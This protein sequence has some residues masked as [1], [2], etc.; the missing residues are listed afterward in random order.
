MC[1]F[2][3]DKENCRCEGVSDV[4]SPGPTQVVWL[5]RPASQLI[6]TI[7]FPFQNLCPSQSFKVGQK[8]QLS[9]LE[10]E[11]AFSSLGCTRS[12]T[13]LLQPPDKPLGSCLTVA[14]GS[15][16]SH[17]RIHIKNTHTCEPQDT[18]KNALNN[19]IHVSPSWEAPQIYVVFIGCTL[20][21]CAEMNV[22]GT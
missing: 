14:V 15:Q 19:T 18:F 20:G 11:R 21:C 12:C 4:T 17:F 5:V 7:P 2:K 13:R 10:E 9:P 16:Q 1:A 22:K 3:C 8:E 6:S